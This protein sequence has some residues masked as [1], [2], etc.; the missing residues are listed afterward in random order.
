M[1]TVLHEMRERVK[2]IKKQR[3]DLRSHIEK[4]VAFSEERI[5]RCDEALVDLAK[6]IKALEAV[7]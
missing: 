1:K 6:V 2:V 3:A 4:E 5:A 7:K